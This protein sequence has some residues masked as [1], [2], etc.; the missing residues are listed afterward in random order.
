MQG[1]PKSEPK[2]WQLVNM[3]NDLKVWLFSFGRGGNKNTHSHTMIFLDSLFISQL[4]NSDLPSLKLT[5]KAP[6]NGWLVY[7]FSLKN[8]GFCH[9]LPIFRGKRKLASFQGGGNW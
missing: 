8:W 2:K 4:Q 5:A 6:E 7:T 9:I 1:A 3:S